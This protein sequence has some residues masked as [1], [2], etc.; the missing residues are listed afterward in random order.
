MLLLQAEREC[1][2]LTSTNAQHAVL[3]PVAPGILYVDD[4]FLLVYYTGLNSERLPCCRVLRKVFY[5]ARPIHLLENIIDILHRIVNCQFCAKLPPCRR[6]SQQLSG[7]EE[8]DLLME[9]EC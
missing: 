1:R 8:L 9:L 4:V 5:Q 3:S 6:E 2:R 7:F